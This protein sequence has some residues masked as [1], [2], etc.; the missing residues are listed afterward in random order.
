MAEEEKK[1]SKWTSSKLW[2]TI[3]S[4]ALLSFVV[5]ANRE[6]FM[7]IAQMLCAVPLTYIGFNVWQKKIITDAEK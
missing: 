3:W 4:M 5:I 7:T 2:I 6:S 1:K